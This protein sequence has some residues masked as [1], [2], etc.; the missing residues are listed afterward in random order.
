MSEPVPLDLDLAAAGYLRSP[1]GQVREIQ[2]LGQLAED[3]RTLGLAAEWQAL[4]PRRP[5]YCRWRDG[6]I[7]L[8]DWLYGSWWPFFIRRVIAEEVAH[9][10]VGPSEDAARLWALR[11]YGEL[12]EPPEW[13]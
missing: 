9:A 12:I 4:G 7:V 8:A 2:G 13:V 10:V 1:S 6:V 11:R 3:A 5:G